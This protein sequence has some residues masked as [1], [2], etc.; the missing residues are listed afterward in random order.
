MRRVAGLTPAILDR[1]GLAVDRLAILG[2]TRDGF[3]EVPGPSLNLYLGERTQYR[4]AAWIDDAFARSALAWSGPWPDGLFESAPI[5]YGGLELVSGGGA[6]TVPAFESLSAGPWDFWESHPLDLPRDQWAQHRLVQFATTGDD[7][8]YVSAG[9]GL[10]MSLPTEASR[11]G[12]VFYIFSSVGAGALDV[13]KYVDGS[14]V[15]GSEYF[16]E[17]PL[18]VDWQVGDVVRAEIEWTTLRVFRNGILLWENTDPTEPILTGGH[19]ALEGYRGLETDAM[20]VTDF[21]AGPL[22][23]EY[24]GLLA[25]TGDVSAGLGLLEPTASPHAWTLSIVNCAPIGGADRFASLLR[26][27]LN[28]GAGTYDIYRQPVR[29]VHVYR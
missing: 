6:V 15:S 19:A 12:Y 13:A 22:R 27:G 24:V 14:P 20:A 23:Q 18:A 26:H 21:A 7:N 4:D 2:M 8:S 11:S 9:I 28:A 10:R 5:S 1:R 29:L 16:E 25:D 3:A 17:F